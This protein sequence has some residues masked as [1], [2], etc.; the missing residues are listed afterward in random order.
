MATIP[1]PKWLNHPVITSPHPNVIDDDRVGLG[2][3]DRSLAQQR[4]ASGALE[5]DPTESGAPVKNRKSFR[6]LKGGR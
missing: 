1:D 4:A 2:R 5:D 3:D 6:N